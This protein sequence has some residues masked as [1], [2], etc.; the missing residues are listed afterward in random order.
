MTMA[1]AGFDIGKRFIDIHVGE[2]GCRF[3]NDKEGFVRLGKFLGQHRVGR[4]VMEAT[5]RFHWRIHRS[6][7]DR[8]PEVCVTTP[9]QARDFA[10][11][12]GEPA[13]SDRA[14][15]R[16][17][18]RFGEVFADLPATKPRSKSWREPMT[19]RSPGSGSSRP[20]RPCGQASASSGTGPR[21][22]SSGSRSG[23]WRKGGRCP[24]E[25]SA[26]IPEPTCRR[27]M[28]SCAPFPASGRSRR[29]RCRSGSPNPARS[30]TARRRRSPA[31]R[32][33]P[34]TAATGRAGARCGPGGADQGAFCIWPRW[35]RRNTTRLWPR[36][37]EDSWK[38]ANRTKW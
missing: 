22:N 15:A 29:R 4:V 25:K 10:R 8:G 26:D 35:P 6:L 5:G 23:V 24:P 13:K 21:R 3:A 33:T 34:A 38:G 36:S 31:W 32:H 30:G 28:P 1:V 2:T 18:A 37:T 27:P 7:A 16:V 14:D 19:C 20:S 11:A 9:R 17:P 12:T